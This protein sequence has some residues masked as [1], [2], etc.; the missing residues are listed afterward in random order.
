M[1]RKISKEEKEQFIIDNNLQDSYIEPIRLFYYRPLVPIRKEVG[2]LMDNKGKLFFEETESNLSRRKFKGK[3][4]EGDLNLIYYNGEKA[5][6]IKDIEVFENEIEPYLIPTSNITLDD[7]HKYFINKTGRLGKRP[8]PTDRKMRNIRLTDEEFK[9]VYSYVSRLRNGQSNSIERN[10]RE[11]LK[12][13]NVMF[14]KI[15]D[16]M[17]IGSNYNH[18]EFSNDLLDIWNYVRKELK[19]D[20]RSGF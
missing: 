9:S 3:T 2:I 7:I 13:I 16:K 8:I 11:Q 10:N 15:S 1:N 6:L 14:Q 12:A 5:V 18:N 17:V 20:V 4:G 19:M